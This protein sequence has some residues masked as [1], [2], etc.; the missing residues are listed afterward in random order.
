MGTTAL[1]TTPP[2]KQPIRSANTTLGTAPAASKHAAN[3]ANVVSA[4]SLSAKATNRH[5]L[6]ANTAQNTCR[7]P[8][9]PQ[10]MANTSPGTHTP[11]RRPR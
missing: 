7:A 5:R 2:F 11:G 6:H 4:R 8:V 1:A 10:S 9:A 3:M